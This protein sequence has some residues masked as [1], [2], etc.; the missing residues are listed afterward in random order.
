[1]GFIDDEQLA[2]LAEPLKETGYGRYLLKVI[3]EGWGG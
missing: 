1:M 2:R 3:R